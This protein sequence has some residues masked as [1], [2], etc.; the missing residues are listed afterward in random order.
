MNLSDFLRSRYRGRAFSPS[1]EMKRLRAS[2]HPVSR[3]TSLRFFGFYGFDLVR[4]SFDSS[5]GDDEA[6]QLSGWHPE[7]AFLGVQ[8]H[9]VSAEIAECLSQI[10]N[11]VG[12][13]LR[14]DDYVAHIGMDIVAWLV[15]QTV[16]V[17]TT[18]RLPR[19]FLTRKAWRH[20][21]TRHRA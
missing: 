13:G 3:W 1:R 12:F 16:F 17:Y 8:P 18:G 21:K 4:I 15:M 6:K 2:T 19:R 11:Q 20:N 10:G 9:V 5:L 14:L 7:K